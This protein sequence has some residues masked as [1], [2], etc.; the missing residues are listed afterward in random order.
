VTGLP[1]GAALA[2]LEAQGFPAPQVDG[3]LA[4]AR[5][6][7]STTPGAGQVP[8]GTVVVLHL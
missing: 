3:P 8:R 1:L 7:R 6:V 4:F 2:A 5:P